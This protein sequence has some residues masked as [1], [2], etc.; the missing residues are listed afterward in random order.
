LLIGSA[1]Y[2]LTLFNDLSFIA[3]GNFDHLEYA[4]IWVIAMEMTAFGM[5]AAL[6][7]GIIAA[8]STYAFQ[9]ITYL[10]PIR[11]ILTAATLRSSSWDRSPQAQAILDDE[12]IGRNKILVI[13]LQG[14]VSHWRTL[15]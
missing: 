13:Q 8:L 4:G 5:T 14:H 3:Y 9:S 12:R 10:N 15:P 6:I 2:V 1:E 11:T 7:A